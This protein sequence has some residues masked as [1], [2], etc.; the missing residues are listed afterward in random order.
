VSDVLTFVISLATSGVASAVVVWIAR[1]WISERLK[2]SIK[3]EYDQKLEM[4]KAQLKAASDLDLEKFK[5]Q[6]QIAAAE[7]HLQF[8]TV[9]SKREEL[10]RE[11]HKELTTAISVSIEAIRPANAAKI[12][13]A[14]AKLGLMHSRMEEVAIYFPAD[15][16][17]RWHESVGNVINALQ[18]LEIARNIRTS[19]IEEDRRIGSD[20]FVKYLD[21]LRA[22]REGLREQVRNQ[23]GV[24]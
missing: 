6:L 3:H 13:E 21:S 1:N 15:F 18:Q 22:I 20:A 16:C 2:N 5:S 7:R 9:F 17:T 4:L 19:N 12:P 14:V 11:L 8:S 10:L 23:I 24:K